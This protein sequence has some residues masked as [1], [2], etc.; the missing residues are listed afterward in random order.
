MMEAGG[1]SSLA[2]NKRSA[3]SS[4]DEDDRDRT[5]H[6]DESALDSPSDEEDDD[7]GLSVI[8]QYL[9]GIVGSTQ[10]PTEEEESNE[11]PL[12]TALKTGGS[13]AAL[14]EYEESL[15]GIR[16]SPEARTAIMDR[17]VHMPTKNNICNCKDCN[18][19]R[20]GRHVSPID[21]DVEINTQQLIKKLV[22][23]EQLRN[24]PECAQIIDEW[25]CDV[26]SSKKKKS[27][28]KKTLVFPMDFS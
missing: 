15:R 9:L 24:Y 12:F 18:N 6:G 2:G 23:G 22:V 21:Y 1:G 16:F 19:E 17:A 3:Q 25:E 8:E 20:Y 27:G 10:Y 4:D 14:S 5:R 11:N 28:K 7:Y 26:F 13:T